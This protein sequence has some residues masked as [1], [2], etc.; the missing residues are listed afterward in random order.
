MDPERHRAF[1]KLSLSHLNGR[2]HLLKQL[3]ELLQIDHTVGILVGQL[4]KLS[5]IVGGPW[6]RSRKLAKTANLIGAYVLVT[7]KH[8]H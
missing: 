6:N 2:S 3:L 4:L 1:T 7:A 8:R 5:Q